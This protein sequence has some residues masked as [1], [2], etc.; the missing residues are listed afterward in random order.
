MNRIDY[1]TWSTYQ[2]SFPGSGCDPHPHMSMESHR[3]ILERHGKST[4]NL[5]TLVKVVSLKPTESS[6]TVHSASLG[7]SLSHWTDMENRTPWM[8]F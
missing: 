1:Q 3:L 4:W 6:M 5:G 7:R 8:D 2:R